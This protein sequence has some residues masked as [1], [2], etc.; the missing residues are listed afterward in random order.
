MLKHYGDKTL[1]TFKFLHVK[2]Q[3]GNAHSLAIV[4]GCKERF[5]FF[6][7]FPFAFHCHNLPR[8]CYLFP[9]MHLLHQKATHPNAR[10]KPIVHSLTT[11]ELSTCPTWCQQLLSCESVVILLCWERTRFALFIRNFQ[12]LW[13]NELL[14][15]GGN[16]CTPHPALLESRSHE[17]RHFVWSA[18]NSSCLQ[19]LHFD[20]CYQ[21]LPSVYPQGPKTWAYD[22]RLNAIKF[23]L[24]F[25]KVRWWIPSFFYS[26]SLI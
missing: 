19:M 21:N 15:S 8:Y 18:K 1:H 23:A 9:Y 20:E 11:W 4:T 17:Q 2:H 25:L 16:T 14:A 5:T 7:W 24:L 13:S 6:Y 10:E 12:K 22:T 3:S 26:H